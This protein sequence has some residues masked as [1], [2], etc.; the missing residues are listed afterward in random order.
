MRYHCHLL[1]I[2]MTPVHWRQSKRS[3]TRHWNSPGTA[4]RVVA[5][6]RPESSKRGGSD[7]CAGR[8]RRLTGQPGNRPGFI[9]GVL[10]NSPRRQSCPYPVVSVI[11]PRHG[12]V[13]R[14][15]ETRLNARCGDQ[16]VRHPV[17]SSL[18]SAK[19]RPSRPL[20]IRILC[21]IYRRGPTMAGHGTGARRAHHIP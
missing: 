4:F 2:S 19:Q 11:G 20:I 17:S 13:Y 3:I 1:C 18:L 12:K 9:E 8:Q 14:A 15:K 10:S 5:P 21:Q 7:A 6:G 16:S